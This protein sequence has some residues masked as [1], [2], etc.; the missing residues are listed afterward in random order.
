[1]STWEHYHGQDVSPSSSKQPTGPYSPVRPSSS[2]G[3]VRLD[4]YNNLQFHPNYGAAACQ[5]SQRASQSHL[6]FFYFASFYCRPDGP[7]ICARWC[8]SQ[9]FSQC[10]VYRIFIP[11]LVRGVTPTRLAGLIDFHLLYCSLFHF[12]IQGEP[13][14]KP[15]SS[16]CCLRGSRIITKFV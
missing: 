7:A 16:S 15:I 11:P 13:L 9:N 6:P 2:A 10:P 4:P 14:M 1:M 5:V 12:S 8:T 3:T